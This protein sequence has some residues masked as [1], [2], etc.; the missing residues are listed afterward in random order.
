MGE[1]SLC[2]KVCVF[3][4]DIGFNGLLLLGLIVV[5]VNSKMMTDWSH[6]VHL[7]PSN[8]V[9]HS[10]FLFV[11]VV[12]VWCIAVLFMYLFC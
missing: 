9:P 10:M 5:W 4:D 8:H 11:A 1:L 12:F 2:G 3:L 6:P 7:L